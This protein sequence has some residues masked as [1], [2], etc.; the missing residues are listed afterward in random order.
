VTVAF[1]VD[2][3]AVD[4]EDNRVQAFVDAETRQ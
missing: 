3:S 2:E 1:A 4:V